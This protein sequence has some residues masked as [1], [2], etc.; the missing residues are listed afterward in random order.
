[1]VHPDNRVEYEF[2][3]STILD[4]D[5]DTLLDIAQ[6]Q[7]ALDKLALFTPRVLTYDCP[8]CAAEIKRANCL[9]NG[10]YCP[11]MPSKQIPPALA[12]VD[13]RKFMEESLR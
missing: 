4:V 6:Y 7:K 8:L 5:F 3:Y 1:M 10:K 2:W 13:G 11:Y 9:G 12:D